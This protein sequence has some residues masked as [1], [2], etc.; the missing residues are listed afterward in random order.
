MRAVKLTSSISSKLFTSSSATF[1]PSIVGVK[2][3]WSLF[4]YSR[5]TIVEMIDA[6]V[7]GR[8]MPLSS[9]SLTSVASGVA[10]RRLGEVLLRPQRFQ[11][12]DFALRHRRQS[13]PFV[14]LRGLVVFSLRGNLIRG[15]VALELHHRPRRPERIIARRDVDARLVI[16]RRNHLRSHEPLPDQ[17]IQLEKIVA[18]IR[19]DVRRFARR[20]RRTDRFV[21]F[22]R[23][24]L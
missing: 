3:P 23:F 13:A 9:N 19:L 10:R 1:S 18:E 7:D 24:F 14:G 11:A 6:Y 17:L 2:R 16:D 8:P 22:L 5:S 20:V 15:Q 21:R 12:Q 4:T